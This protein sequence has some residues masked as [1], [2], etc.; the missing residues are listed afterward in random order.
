[1][2]ARGEAV[3]IIIGTPIAAHTA[4]P[5][6]ELTKEILVTRR[7]S[8]AVS[9]VVDMLNVVEAP[10]AA[11]EVVHHYTDIQS[12]VHPRF[13]QQAILTKLPGDAI[14]C[15]EENS[16][17][18]RSLFSLDMFRFS[19]TIWFKLLVFRSE[20]KRILLTHQKAFNRRLLTHGDRSAQRL[21]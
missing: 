9:N 17:K 7:D 14:R 3:V 13:F 8:I 16:G 20:I 19:S 10:K 2:G 12:I 11:K 18:P 15:L 21:T 5:V 6:G 4:H 1:V